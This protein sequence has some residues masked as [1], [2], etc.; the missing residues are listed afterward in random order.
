MI[1]IEV[2]STEVIVKSGNSARTGKPYSIREQVAV[3]AF[4]HDRDG[5]PNP[6]PTRVSVTLRDEQE[7]YPVGLYTLAPESLYADRFAQLSLV[8]VLRSVASNK[9]SL[10]SA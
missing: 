10:K 8:P 4:L 7:P 5:K 3:Y 6:Y 9:A 1:N 2:K